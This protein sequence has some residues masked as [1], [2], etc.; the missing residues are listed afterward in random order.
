VDACKFASLEMPCHRKKKFKI[1]VF[2]QGVNFIS[3]LFLQV[4]S[5]FQSIP[6]VPEFPTEFHSAF[7]FRL[8]FNGVYMP[9]EITQAGSHQ[10]LSYMNDLTVEIVDSHS[11][12]LFWHV[13]NGTE[14][15]CL[16]DDS[17]AHAVEVFPDLS[18]FKYVGKAIVQG[19]ECDWY[20]KESDRPG[21]VEHFYY[22]PRLRAPVRWSM[23]ARDSIFDSHLDDYIVDYLFT[24]PLSHGDNL[25]TIPEICK[26]SATSRL[27]SSSGSSSWTK[28][29][30]RRRDKIV[31][32]TGYIPLPERRH[33]EVYG[34]QISVSDLLSTEKVSLPESFD[35]RSNHGVPDRVKDQAFCGSC[36][37]FSVIAS[38]ESAFM[39][40]KNASSRPLSE[41][42]ILDCGWESG[43]MSCSGGNQQQIG[44]LLM[45]KFAG[46]VPYDSDYGQYLSTYSYCKNI[47]R[48]NGIKI[49]GWVNLP[50]RPSVTLIKKSIVRYGMLSV[51]INAVDEI[52]FYTGGIVSTD[53]C[54]NTRAKDLNHAVNLVGYATDPDTG[55]EYWILRNSWSDI[56]GEKG[57]FRVELGDRDCGISIDVS[58]PIVKR[59]LTAET[60]DS[61]TVVA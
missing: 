20:T 29:W 35:W 21:E 54:K 23:H 2:M 17:G 37:A 39:V 31:F 4:S 11:G 15:T 58:F 34:D 44:P 59:T 57:F 32:S 5:G 7:V 19:L 60:N 16:L 56:W 6:E 42:F 10:Q 26:K 53:A 46:F 18:T 27:V 1:F 25:I 52:V 43:S 9:I 3:V 47:T 24:R 55:T 48:M 12:K 51:S 41:Q 50:S 13:F 28:R 36:Y 8:P 61:Y 45:E 30:R 38:V 22:D 49:D 40:V 33:I 14:R